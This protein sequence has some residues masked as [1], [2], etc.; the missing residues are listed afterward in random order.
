MMKKT[1]KHVIRGCGYLEHCGEHP[2][3]TVFIMF[4]LIGAL[5]A[6]HGGWKGSLF[7]AGFMT[8]FMSPLYL[9]GAYDRSVLDERMSKRD[10]F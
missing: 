5:A 1:I 4:I 10:G 8:T 3:T 7:G 6:G 2:G 9:W